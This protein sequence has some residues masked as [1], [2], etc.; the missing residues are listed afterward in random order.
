M[1]CLRL[2]ALTAMCGV[3]LVALPMPIAAQE[4]LPLQKGQHVRLSAPFA[5]LNR[6]EATVQ[7]VRGSWLIVRPYWVSL[8]AWRHAGLLAD[9]LGVAV[10][11]DSLSRLEVSVATRR[12]TLIGA[13]VG[14]VLLG[15]VG[16]LSAS[17]CVGIPCFSPALIGG[18][19]LV[20]GGLVGGLIGHEIL[21][22]HWS[23]VALGSRPIGARAR[24]AGRLGFGITVSI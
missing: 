2:A 3:G 10:P 23:L 6:A 5:G 22:D 9:S 15:T 16:A 1:I 19:G 4:P 13:G 14:G 11:I 21:S 17:H 18:A 24:P 8:P 20:L 7:G 12:H